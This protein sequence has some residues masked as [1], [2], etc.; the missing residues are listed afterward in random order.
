MK[1]FHSRT[2]SSME[3]VWRRKL[4][5]IR[6]KL[7][8]DSNT[9]IC[10]D[11]WLSQNRLSSHETLKYTRYTSN[12]SLHP[13]TAELFSGIISREGSNFINRHVTIL[14]TTPEKRTA[15]AVYLDLIRTWL[16]SLCSFYFPSK[17]PKRYKFAYV[18][19]M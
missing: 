14:L 15:A 9:E 18:T 8:L 2:L 13:C 16:C 6:K 5:L 4:E 7:L 3:A 19:L 1:S 11:F 12:R 10:R 17:S